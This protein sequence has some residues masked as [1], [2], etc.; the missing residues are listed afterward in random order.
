MSDLRAMLIECGEPVSTVIGRAEK[1][2]AEKYPALLVLL[3]EWAGNLRITRG[4]S[5]NTVAQYVEAVS[6]FGTWLISQDKTLEDLTLPLADEWQRDLYVRAKQGSRTRSLKLTAL[7]QF[8]QWREDRGD[9][10]NPVRGLRGPRTRK[11]LP[12][13]YS[14]AELKALLGACDRQMLQGKR[15]Y[16]L[17]LVLIST[18]MRVSEAAGLLLEQ[19]DL[20]QRVGRVQ[21]FGKGAKERSVSFEGPLIQA[22]LDWLEARAVLPLKNPQRVFASLRHD[23]R[24]APLG[25]RGL[26][27]ALGQIK[28][29]AALDVRVHPHKFRVTYATKLYDEG[30]EL[31]E[32]RVLLGHESIETTRQYLSVA[33]RTRRARLSGRK[34]SVLT[35]EH[36][37]TPLWVKKKLEQRGHSGEE[38]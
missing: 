31:E 34:L 3:L 25:R 36:S 33:E 37:A 10:P 15:D 7:R 22:L 2:L 30:H 19:L 32:I 12:K 29:R 4:L 13:K 17:L 18:G 38:T 35:G 8:C 6:Q 20:K 28:K 27:R 16:A 26:Q 21:F 11:A 5:L 1:R 14:D 23:S 9:A 24:G